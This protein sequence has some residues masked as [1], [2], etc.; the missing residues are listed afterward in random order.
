MTRNNEINIAEGGLSQIGGL[1]G[2]HTSELSG[3]LLKCKYQQP[4][5]S[6]F[7]SGMESWDFLIC[8]L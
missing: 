3:C 8:F 6:E 1:W 4:M 5:G 7:W 2:L